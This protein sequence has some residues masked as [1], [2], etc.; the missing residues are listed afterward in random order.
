MSPMPGTS[1]IKASKPMRWLRARDA[2]RRRRATTRAGGGDARPRSRLGEQSAD[3]DLPE[4]RARERVAEGEDARHFVGASSSRQ[5]R[6]EG[7]GG[8]VA[9]EHDGGRDDLLV[10]RGGEPEDRDVGDGGMRTERG[11][12]LGGVDLVARRVDE[13][14][15][16]PG[17]REASAASREPRSRV[18]Q[19]TR[20]RR[21]STAGLRIDDLADARRRRARAVLVLDRD[22]DVAERPCRRVAGSTSPGAARSQV[23]LPASVRP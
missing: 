4:R 17:D 3:Q 11:L 8:R 2:E 7:V 18:A 5:W 1:P 23:T 15:R 22:R 10:V 9:R 12:D 20:R 6:A 21:P 14:A 19:R 16:A 13:E